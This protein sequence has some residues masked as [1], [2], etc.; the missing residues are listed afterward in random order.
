MDIGTAKVT[1]REMDGVPHFL[2]DLASPRITFTVAQFQRKALEVIRN[3][4]TETPIFVV[5]GSPFYIEAILDPQ[6]Y[7]EVRPDPALRKRLSKRSTSFLF[8]MLQRKDPRRANTIDRDNPRRL[9]RALEIVETLGVVPERR[10]TSPYH[11]LKI[12]ISLPRAKL[13]RNIDRRVDGR[14]PGMLNETRRLH[15]QGISWKR[16]EGFGLEYRWMSQILKKQ[17]TRREGV[18]RLK[19]DI[20][21]FARRQL[22]WW[23]KDGT[24]R[25]ITNR[26]SAERL[27]ARFLS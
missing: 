20:H 21:A 26:R 3:I 18:L 27:A 12:G 8:R 23:R 15:A 25:W 7:P 9:I 19:G 2:L 10:T 14:M 16:L 24:T 22:T 13:Y 11:V 1:K 5:G 6:P 4:P 17:L